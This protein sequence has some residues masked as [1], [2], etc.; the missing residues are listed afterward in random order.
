MSAYAHANHIHK[1]KCHIAKA[2]KSQQW[3]ESPVCS[4]EARREAEA[5]REPAEEAWDA[6]EVQVRRDFGLRNPAMAL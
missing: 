4:L 5:P 3:G 1:F 2:K 6:L